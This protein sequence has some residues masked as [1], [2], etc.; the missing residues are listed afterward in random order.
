MP[1]ICRLEDGE[2]RRRRNK[3]ELVHARP[4]N[5]ARSARRWRSC[6]KSERDHRARLV[7]SNREGFTYYKHISYF[8]NKY[9]L[10]LYVHVY[11][12][13]L[14]GCLLDFGLWAKTLRGQQKQISL[15]RH[16]KIDFYTCLLL[17]FYHFLFK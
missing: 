7:S 13:G 3:R 1:I 5:A 11:T 2:A 12:W 14:L 15:H 10:S 17:L 9:P 16:F 6:C 4:S 8:F